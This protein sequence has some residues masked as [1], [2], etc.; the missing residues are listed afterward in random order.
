MSEFSES[1]HLKNGSLEDAISLLKKSHQT[2]FVAKASDE[3][4]SLVPSSAICSF[5]VDTDLI[6]NNTGILLQYVSAEDHCFSF[7]IYHDSQ[8]I[9]EYTCDINNVLG[10]F[11]TDVSI[12]KEN[13]NSSEIVKLINMDIS[14][15]ELMRILTPRNFNEYMSMSGEF[16]EKL[17][18]PPQAYNWISYH[19]CELLQN[20]E[21]KPLFTFVPA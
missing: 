4:V 18:I 7:R 10:D 15:K 14:E 19:Y 9:S 8:I 1:Y 13:F 16:M 2:G 11:E 20:E 5:S 12:D 6:T 17:K 21:E 3:W